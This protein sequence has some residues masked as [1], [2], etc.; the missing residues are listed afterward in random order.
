MSQANTQA[1]VVEAV[2]TVSVVIDE[3]RSRRRFAELAHKD[4]AP[5]VHAAVQYIG[6]GSVLEDQRKQAKKYYGDDSEE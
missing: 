6:L 4:L 2:D 3:F 5:Y 1:D